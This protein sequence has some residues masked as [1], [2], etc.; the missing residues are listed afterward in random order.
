MKVLFQ[1]LFNNANH[2][3][4]SMLLKLWCN[5]N[6]LPLLYLNPN[7]NKIKEE[8]DLY[9]LNEKII[10]IFPKCFPIIS[11]SLSKQ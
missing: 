6:P 2:E 3:L 9:C 7:I 5:T 10:Y 11:F 4:K 1:I 8:T